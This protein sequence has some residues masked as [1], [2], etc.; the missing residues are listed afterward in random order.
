[1]HKPCAGCDK[2]VLLLAEAEPPAFAKAWHG[3]C[4]LDY[5]RGIVEPAARLAISP[6][7]HDER[8]ADGLE[9]P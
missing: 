4:Y 9:Q 6:S 8:V 1:M 2:P 7:S 5:L 3:E